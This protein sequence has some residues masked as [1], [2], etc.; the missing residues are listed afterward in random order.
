MPPTDPAAPPAEGEPPV[1]ERVPP[2]REHQHV[3]TESQR[4]AAADDRVAWWQVLSTLALFAAALALLHAAGWAPWRYALV[5]PLA[6]LFIRVFV[7]QHD[8]GHLSLFGGRKR[9]DAVGTL[10]ATV[11]GVPYHAWRTEHNWHHAHQGK[12]SRRGVDSNNSPPTALEAAAAPGA[13]AK[14]DR[15]VSPGFIF[16]MG[17]LSLMVFRKRVKGFFFFR[18]AYRWALPDVGALRRSV[19]LTNALHAAFML[20]LV[21]WLGPLQWLTAVLPA[22]A[23][24]CG[25]GGLLF[26]VQHNFEHTY[27]APDE[28]W[29][30]A[31]AGLQGSSYLRLPRLLAWFTAH[32]G[33]HHVHHVNVRIPN[34]RLEEARRGVPALA[35]IA[36]LSRRDLAR[37]FTC[38]FW[39]EAR[40]RLVPLG[41]VPPAPGA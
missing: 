9:N 31:L 28:S 13:S 30:F 8:C 25:I 5:L 4:F 14:R 21:L 41:E 10:L 39:D 19:R 22:M 7:L 20:A 2:S 37:C 12:L 29:D 32:I 15:L 18:D 24:A 36:P 16:A 26:W 3:L 6:G 34:Y 23:I 33:V 38:L 35:A 11:T 40:G 17:P 1:V 27:F